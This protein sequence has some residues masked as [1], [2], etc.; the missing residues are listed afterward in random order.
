[1][2]ATKE[3]SLKSSQ[4]V[5]SL[6]S[7]AS[8]SSDNSDTLLTPLFNQKSADTFY[9]LQHL[10]KEVEET[11]EIPT[12]AKEVLL[13]VSIP[14]PELKQVSLEIKGKESETKSAEFIKVI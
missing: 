10:V 6:S 1:M 8:S 12:R 3:K 5:E 9:I 14:I 11:V 2:I 7:H 13:S 4:T